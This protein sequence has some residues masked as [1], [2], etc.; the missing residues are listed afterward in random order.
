MLGAIIGDIVGSR[1][2]QRNLK[3]KDFEFFARGCCPTDDS[4]MTLAV[5]QA[6]LKCKLGWWGLERRAIASMQD[7]GRRYPL[8]YGE[9]F[10][11]WLRA[12]RPKPYNSFGNGAAMRVSPCAWAARSLEEALKLSD[13]VTAVSH[14]HPEAIKGARAV[15]TAIYLALHGADQRQIRDA[16]RRDYYRLDLTLNE[17]RPDY[18]FDVSCQGS[19]PE[20]LEAFLEARD[21]EDTVR[22]A[23]SIGGDSD[24]IAAI[25]GS[26]G[27][28]YFG[29]PAGMRDR[30]MRHLDSRQRDIVNAFEN[31]YGKRVLTD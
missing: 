19:V 22:N 16:L 26:I 28:A 24:T 13:R 20:A 4:T 15:T 14:D 27:E 2:E 30:A 21:F 1:F 7:L 31:K 23:V 17:I 18:Y 25:A 8:G 3:S 29:I 10:R 9:S 12:D 6:L 5:A 11:D